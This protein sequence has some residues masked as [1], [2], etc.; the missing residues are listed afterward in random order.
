VGE[1]VPDGEQEWPRARSTARWLKNELLEIAKYWDEL[2]SGY[3]AFERSKG[4]ESET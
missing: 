1:E 2:R 3:E 4:S